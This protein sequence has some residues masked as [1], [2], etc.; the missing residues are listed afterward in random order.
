VSGP[1]D[2]GGLG[3]AWVLGA[4]AWEAAGQT[5]GSGGRARRSR[6]I[7]VALSADGK[8]RSWADPVTR[9]IAARLGFYQPAAAADGAG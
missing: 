7:G 3:A 1:C 4:V 8:L 5:L 2:N 9:A 6:D